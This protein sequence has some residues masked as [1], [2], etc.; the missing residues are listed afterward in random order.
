VRDSNGESQSEKKRLERDRWV[1]TESQTDGWR[2]A[3]AGWGWK[4]PPSPSSPPRCLGEG[5]RPGNPARL[6]LKGGKSLQSRPRINK[7]HW[8]RGAAA[9]GAFSSGGPAGPE[10]GTPCPAEK[11]RPQEA[12][13]TALPWP[14]A[15]RPQLLL[16]ASVSPLRPDD[17][18]P[19]LCCSPP[20][21]VFPLTSLSRKQRTVLVVCGPEQ[22][23][24]VGLVCARHLR[25]FVSKR[26]PV[27]PQGQPHLVPVEAASSPWWSPQGSRVLGQ[28]CPASTPLSHPRSTS[29][30]SS[31]PLDRWTG[32]TGT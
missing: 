5:P 9:G 22:N 16:R 26:T 28:G 18:C 20:P 17:P 6:R 7:P 23:G 21:Q 19:F 29:P 24:A 14:V 3:S 13:H 11:L 4:S 2:E 12:K 25:V 27:T 31:T 1:E 15:S 8:G 32:C 30:R 10:M